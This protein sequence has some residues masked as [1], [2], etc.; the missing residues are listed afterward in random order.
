MTVILPMTARPASPAAPTHGTPTWFFATRTFLAMGLAFALPVFAA[1]ISGRVA[2]EH[3]KPLPGAIIRAAGVSAAAN[4]D[5]AFT[6]EIA[7]G[8]HRLVISMEGFDTR[9][10]RVSAPGVLEEIRLH[11]GND[12]VTVNA[13]RAGKTAPV[14]RSEMDAAVIAE[15]NHGQDIPALLTA[16]PGAASYGEAGGTG[17]Y[18]YFSLRG[19][20]QS[21]LNLTLDGVP[22]S[23][24]EE[25]QFFFANLGDLMGSLN[26]LQV[27]RGAGTSTVGAPAFGGSVNFASTRPAA[28][29][30]LLA[31]LGAGSYGT[32]H[33]SLAG[34]SGEFGSGLA[35]YG[36]YSHFDADGYRDHSGV[37]QDSGFLTARQTLG[38]GEL[39]LTAFSGLERSHL[40]FYAS[41]PAELARN[42]RANGN[43]PEETDR[44]QQHLVQLAWTA[45][46]GAH[47][48]YR[49][50]AY[51]NGA[52]GWFDLWDTNANLL[53]YQID[54]QSVGGFASWHQ[55]I[56]EFSFDGGA[57][58]YDFKRE[59]AQDNRTTAAT[60]YRNSGRKHGVDAFL[61]GG[62][63]HAR[64]HLFADAQWR[65]A[66]FSYAGDVAIAPVSWSFF[67]PKA[68]VRY[69]FTEKLSG[70]IS[71]GRASRE[72]AR[73]DLLAG[74]DNASL[75]Y[76]LR[77]VHP[78][79][80][81]DFE[82]GL[83]YKRARLSAS[84]GLYAMEFRNEIAATGELTVVGYPLR[85][86]TERSYRRGLELELHGRPCEHWK[87]DSALN[88]SRNR[89]ARWN[90]FYDIYDRSGNYIAS[91]ARTLNDVRPL[92][93][94]E[95]I[96]TQSLAWLNGRGDQAG[97][98]A[99]YVGE[100]YLDNTQNA[101]TRL[102]GWFK[103]DF[104]GEFSLTRF[105]GR[106]D[107]AL[108]LHGDNLLDRRNFASGYSY[109][110]LVQN[111][112]GE[113]ATGSPYLYPQSGRGFFA[114]LRLRY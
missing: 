81:N 102:A 37:K 77:A 9:E 26:S 76:D 27:Q 49:I 29:P 20:A 63:D 65:T 90:Q 16:T 34:H 83:D 39:R 95:L 109:P 60:V 104:D 55:R 78:E 3:G 23:D 74:E 22:L 46:A 18:S 1:Q 50:S 31:D 71:A 67:N 33:L 25:A 48:S 86:N 30:E 91:E 80:V 12:T 61:K 2:D 87:F 4:A 52:R 101:D 112:G 17:G 21:R 96:V 85:R 105:T 98:T 93:S 66:T 35:V 54:G 38:S 88:L 42:P 7:D 72:P 11:A 56:N 44:F 28:A 5:G 64:W 106:L 68:G 108:R 15:N 99:H 73:S 6:L 14:T 53:R 8:G 103:L 82:L 69:D 70:F 57:H 111:G 10:M 32:Q 58:Y 24:P 113:T 107:A 110:F 41:T 97:L 43:A 75:A 79:T 59:H 62:W 100:S 13:I 45:P 84:A 19:I 89:I 36:R 51:Y 40:A 47:A 92:L 94:P 114:A